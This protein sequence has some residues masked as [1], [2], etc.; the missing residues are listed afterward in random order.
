MSDDRN[1]GPQDAGRGAT[2]LAQ[3]AGDRGRHIQMQPTGD[4]KYCWRA[5]AVTPALAARHLRGALTL[6]ADL[7]R[8]DGTTLALCWDVDTPAGW[9]LLHQA[10]A[11]LQATGAQPILERSP[12]GR[13]GHLW[14][15]FATPVDVEAARATALGHAPA[16]APVQECWPHARGSQV[17]VR[18][19]AGFYRR[20]GVAAWCA[21][22]GTDR[23]TWRTGV[24]AMALI[25]DA[26]MPATWVQT[27]ASPATRP[28]ASPPP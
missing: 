2:Y 3:L 9:E 15:F 10:A 13:G 5:G 4:A 8:A 26:R 12:A 22:A 24:D 1:P 28:A 18:L 27:P 23:A 17:A 21:L 20:P 19:P 16:L 14:L 25:L 6:G 11:Q 7:Q